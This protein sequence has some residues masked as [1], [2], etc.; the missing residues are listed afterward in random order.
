MTRR[1]RCDQ[2]GSWH[3]VVNRGLA[4]RPLF[5]DRHDVRFFLSRLAR[6]VRRGRLEIHAY[7]VLTTHF[8]LLV[9]SP[10]G[11]LSEAM[12]RAQNEHSRM[13]NRRRRRDGTLIRGRYLSKPVDSLEYRWNL[14][15][16]IDQNPVRAGLSSEPWQ[17]PWCS[18]AHYI[19]TSGPSWL[20][21]GW[22]EGRIRSV[23]N[24]DRFHGKSYARVLGPN[25]P[26]GSCRLIEQRLESSTS[27]PDDLDDL[28]GSA[29]DRVRDWMM[30]KARLADGSSL[31]VA[32]CDVTSVQ[33]AI[34]SERQARGPWDLRPRN[35]SRCGWEL[36]EVGLLRTL[37]GI[38][39]QRIASTTGTTLS[40]VRRRLEIHCELLESDATYR[41]RIGELGARALSLCHGPPVGG[42]RRTVVRLGMV[43]ARGF[44]PPT[45][46]TP[47]QR[48]SQAA[49]RPDA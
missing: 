9:R 40:G 20:E 42:N 18:A 4:R 45:S 29:P 17:Y 23:S 47:L 1:N 14:V 5:E 21:R 44:E 3:H 25:L 12:R 34:E 7:C 15:R 48:A 2:P 35:R 26:E 22:V 41:G 11:E 31:G 32:V 19:H 30:R 38:A 16:Y 36:A 10:L 33:R 49:P 27:G 13:F 37:A 24:E 46:A 8:H 6:E 39:H 43:G 28:I